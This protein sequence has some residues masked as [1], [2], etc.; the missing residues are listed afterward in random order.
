MKKYILGFFSFISALA[1]VLFAFPSAFSVGLCTDQGAGFSGLGGASSVMTFASSDNLYALSG[2]KY[3]I[4]EL[5]GAS[6]NY[7][8]ANG[9]REKETF[10]YG[11]NNS[12][13]TYVTLNE[14][15]KA[16]LN[17]VSTSCITSGLQTTVQTVFYKMSTGLADLISSILRLFF[18]NG[19]VCS[20]T[21]TEG[22]ID[23]V[24]IAGDQ[25]T[26]LISAFGKG[27]FLPL[28]TFIFLAVAIWLAYNGVIKHQFRMGIGGVIWALFAFFLGLF[29][30][31]KPMMVAQ[32]P[33]DATTLI[34]SCILNVVAGGDCLSKG[35]GNQSALQSDPLCSTY[36]DNIDPKT[37]VQLALETLTCRI[38]KGFTIDYWARQEFGYGIDD[39]YTKGAPKGHKV[40]PEEKLQGSPDDYCV[41]LYSKGS[42]KDAY[43]GHTSLQMSNQAM[44]CNI[45]VAYLANNSSSYQV[46]NIDQ[47]TGKVTVK[48]SLTGINFGLNKQGYEMNAS[49]IATAA[50]DDTMWASV[51]GGGRDFIGFSQMVAVLLTVITFVP[52]GV[53]GVAY[54]VGS[55]V[56]I[57]FAPI[58]LL[59]GIHPGRGKKIFL[60]W[61]E[62]FLSTVMKY[63]A[64]GILLVIMVTF[65]STVFA[66]MTGAKVLV[67]T[68]ILAS[69]FLLYRKELTNIIGTVNLGGVKVTNKLKEKV[70]KVSNSANDLKNAA[71]GGAIGGKLG[72]GTVGQG[73]QESVEM[74]LRRNQGFVGDVFRGKQRTK[75]AL[76]TEK[77]AAIRRT[78]REAER[79]ESLSQLQSIADAL[80]TRD[81]KTEEVQ[82]TDQKP[83]NPGQTTQQTGHKQTEAQQTST[84]TPSQA[85]TSKQHSTTQRSIEERPPMT[86]TSADEQRVDKDKE[87]GDNDKNVKKEDKKE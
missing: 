50:K 40:F 59:L 33:Q 30:V 84:W 73:M 25:N 5:F 23:L 56:L 74:Q 48:P 15:Q 81:G 35:T 19:F 11:K 79:Q 18:N 78:E 2:R 67:A 7:A 62:S 20:D 71:I 51:T 60:G 12:V 1:C 49:I 4:T 34:S 46:T 27:V 36:A 43:E 70:D 13:G 61:L 8:T 58:F 47:T 17:S 28:S 63:F 57:I 72:G 26:G 16:R 54:S 85:Q 76:K 87:K 9:Q 39:L 64:T 44:V 22:C 42:A 82:T 83:L 32:I 24:G 21:I 52:I 14:T 86:Y 69:V 41:N 53:L 37:Q 31:Y 80:K 77:D 75:N 66:T 3:N 55:Q 45:A 65:Y 29:T 68:I 38:Q 6:T 10:L